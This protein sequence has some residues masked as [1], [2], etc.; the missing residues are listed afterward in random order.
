MKNTPQDYILFRE[1]NR[2]AEDQDCYL[3]ANTVQALPMNHR[4]AIMQQVE[5]L[6][7][8][9]ILIGTS[10]INAQVVANCL[11]AKEKYF[12]VWSPEW[13]SLQE[14]SAQQLNKIFYNKE[15]SL[16]ARSNGHFKLLSKLFKEP[17]AVI[18]NWNSKQIRE[19]LCKTFST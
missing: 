9:G 5:A 3:F 6:K 7:H 2:L 8:P 14:Y 4:F 18:N 1:L 16:I 17:A 12:Y 13:A 19:E 10:M 15:I 11:T